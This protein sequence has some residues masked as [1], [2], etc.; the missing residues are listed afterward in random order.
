MIYKY[1]KQTSCVYI[2]IIFIE[3]I[4]INNDVEGWHRHLNSKAGRGQLDLYLLIQL[5]GEEAA[6]VPIQ[7]DLLR[8]S[9]VTRRQRNQ[10]TT[11]RLFP[12]WDQLQNEETTPRQLLRAASHIIP[13]PAEARFEQDAQFFL[14]M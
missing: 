14:K 4:R 2:F 5:L 8:M 11:G 13:V 9:V 1:Y 6:L 10:R 3:T 12:L 7:L